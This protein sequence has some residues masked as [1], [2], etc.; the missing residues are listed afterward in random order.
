VVRKNLRKIL[1]EL[2]RRGPVLMLR[3][4]RT[5]GGFGG[6]KAQKRAKA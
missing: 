6:G 3:L 1:S 5:F 4:K 2:P